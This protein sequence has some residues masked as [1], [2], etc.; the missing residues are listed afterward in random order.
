M[1]EDFKGNTQIHK[2]QQQQ[3]RAGTAWG[4]GDTYVSAD[5]G[6]GDLDA[7]RP[8][9]TFLSD[10]LVFREDGLGLFFAPLILVI[11]VV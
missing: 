9:Q 7:L 11:E 2:Q 3:R 6:S 8:P 4:G 1:Q 10:G 5:F